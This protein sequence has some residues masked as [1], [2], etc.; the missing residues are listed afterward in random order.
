VSK[1]VAI[2][3]EVTVPDYVDPDKTS[4][5]VFNFLSED[6]NDLFPDITTVNSYDYKLL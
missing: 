5:A 3:I 2:M 1:T 4:E 6:P